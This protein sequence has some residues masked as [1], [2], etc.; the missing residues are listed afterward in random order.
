MLR[1]LIICGL[2]F[3]T[4]LTKN[5][6]TFDKPFGIATVEQYNTLTQS[7]RPIE[8]N[9]INNRNSQKST[10]N[11]LYATTGTQASV[12]YQNN[13]LLVILSFF[14][15]GII[16]AFTPCVFPMLPILL[17]IISGKNTTIKKTFL[18]AL[19]YIL[20][21]ALSYAI[22]G[23]L[24]AK[25][26]G[27]IQNFLQNPVITIGI[28]ILFII[29]SLSLFGLFELR[30]PRIVNHTLTR[31]MLKHNQIGVTGAFIAGAISALILSPC[32]TAPLAGALLYI[33]STGNTLIGGV[34]LFMLG[35]GSGIPLLGIAVFGNNLLPKSGKWMN[36]VKYCLAY[37]MLLMAIYFASRILNNYW[38]NLILAIF[39]IIFSSHIF[40]LVLKH[41]LRIIIKIVLILSYITLTL[42]NI[43][44]LIVP[45]FKILFYPI[46]S[47]NQPQ[48]DNSSPQSPLKFQTI[49]T[50]HELNQ[51]LSLAKKNHMPAI[52]D[53]SAKWCMACKEMDL[54]TFHDPKIINILTNY[55]KIRVD[56]TANN[57]ETL[58][59]QKKYGVFAPPSLVFIDQDGNFRPEQTIIGYINAEKLY[60]IISTQIHNQSYPSK[61][62]PKLQ[63][64]NIQV[65]DLLFQK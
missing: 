42:F 6:L 2:L 63:N 34:S 13:L 62:N 58:A 64:Y 60:A 59:L 50:R 19:S 30:L 43:F 10:F 44:Y 32:V 45:S 18:L 25:L 11:F 5:Y 7:N 41:N 27:H 48:S 21:N 49:N 56:I 36:I 24:A 51:I 35:L 33:S 14:I 54:A 57:N 16:L 23:I 55:I 29:F 46:S 39:L 53:F 26:G 3:N 38:T 47:H 12:I 40:L 52:L 22:A 17:A 9:N 15:S 61:P 20:G 1:I 8:T 4:A 28:T 37:L 31:I 65:G